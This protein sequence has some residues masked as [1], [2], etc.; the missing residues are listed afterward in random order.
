MREELITLTKKQHDRLEIIR[1]LMR[2]ELKQKVAAEMMGLSTRQVRNLV[3]KVKQDGAR[4]L[5]HGNRGQPSPKRLARELVERIVALVKEHYRG[6]KPKFAAE[7]LWTRDRIRVSDEKMRQI[8]IEAGLW[9]V[10]RQKS[11]VHPWREPKAY[12]GEMVQLDGSHHAWLENR[13][14]KLVLMGLVDDARN[15]F[16]GRF[17]EYEGVFPAM[18]VLRGYIRHYGLPRSLYV[19]KHSTYKTVRHPSEDEMLRGEEASTQFE[20]AAQELGIKIIHAHSPQAKGRIERAFGTLQDRLVKEMRLAGISTLEEANRFLEGYLP[21]FN[22]QFEREPR[23]AEDL[24]RPLPKGLKLEEIFCLKAVR[25][26]LDGYVIC[27]KGKRFAIQEPRRRMLGR[28]ATVMLHFDGRMV[29]RFEGRDL[30]YREIPE[31]PKC[32]ATAPVVR[33]KPP[34]YIP[35]PT[36]P[37]RARFLRSQDALPER[38]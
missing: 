10:R 1:R 37:W 13:G 31:R 32:V 26:I 28:P 3:R 6:F 16:Y 30:A 9:R 27:R 34:K 23:E 4:G 35:P 14:P 18:D 29:I 7:K 36:H 12:C 17:Y 11:E 5:A 24:H 2:R 22:A 8:M 19:D 15:R 38:P 21:R 25:T 33:P 20:R